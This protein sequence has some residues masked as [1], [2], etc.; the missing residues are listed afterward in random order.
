MSL[1]RGCERAVGAPTLV[2]PLPPPSPYLDTIEITIQLKKWLKPARH[3][4]LERFIV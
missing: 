1:Y 4:A 2:G 3:K